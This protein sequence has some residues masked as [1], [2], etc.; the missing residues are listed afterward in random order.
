MPRPRSAGDEVERA[1]GRLRAAERERRAAIEE[2][3]RLGVVRSR[4]FVGDLG[5]QIAAAYYGVELAPAFTPG[6]DLVDGRDKRVQVKTL[7][8]TP[9]RPRTIIGGI[10]R[11]CDVVLAIRLDFDYSPT[12]ALEMPVEVAEEYIGKNGKLGWTHALA[13]DDRVHR[14]SASELLN[15]RHST[16]GGGEPT[17]PATT[18]IE[19]PRHHGN[20]AGAGIRLIGPEIEVVDRDGARRLVLPA[21]D[22]YSQLWARLPA[23]EREWRPAWGFHPDDDPNSYPPNAIF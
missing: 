11:P 4:V 12:E 9:T 3:V 2:L 5:E 13:D 6:Y 18:N 19:A 8:A 16:R 21:D 1:M 22:D 20:H 10:T 15:A 7:R 23:T 14:I 17:D